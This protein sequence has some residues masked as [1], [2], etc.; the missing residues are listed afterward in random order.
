LEYPS[1]IQQLSRLQ[2]RVIGRLLSM[3][4]KNIKRRNNE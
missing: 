1:Q 4:N 2:E 3:L